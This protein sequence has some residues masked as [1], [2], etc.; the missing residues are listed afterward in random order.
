[1]VNSKQLT[2]KLTSTPKMR[3]RSKW[4]MQNSPT[5][6][7]QNDEYNDELFCQ[8]LRLHMKI[9]GQRFHIKTPFT[10]WDM[11]VW[12]MWKVLFTNIEKQ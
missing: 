8:Y 2:N 9:V 7:V 11:R 3:L 4:V 1:M 10:F 5:T 12:D 6:S